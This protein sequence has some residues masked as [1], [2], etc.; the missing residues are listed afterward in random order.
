MKSISFNTLGIVDSY[1]KKEDLVVK[2]HESKIQV[3]ITKGF[4]TAGYSLEVSRIENIN[5]G[6]KIYLKIVPPK[7]DC[8]QLQVMTYKTITLE[9][10]KELIG[11]NPYKFE[12]EDVESLPCDQRTA[13]ER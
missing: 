8:M 13:L 2:T 4:P 9:I 3:S 12:L 1:C 6:Y 11:N 5:E 10:D 7:V